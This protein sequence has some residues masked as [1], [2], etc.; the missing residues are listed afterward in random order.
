MRLASK[1]NAFEPSPSLMSIPADPVI[2]EAAEELCT[3]PS[4]A[5]TLRRFVLLRDLRQNTIS[6][7]S[8]PP[9]LLGTY[10]DGN[11]S[12]TEADQIERNVERVRNQSQ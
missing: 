12:N 9:S 6:R 4:K 1:P 2:E 11:K 3:L 8:S 10:I 5:Q 7:M